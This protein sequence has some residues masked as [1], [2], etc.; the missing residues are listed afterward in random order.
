MILPVSS[1]SILTAAGTFG[2]PGIVMIAPVR[3]TMKPAPAEILRL[4]TVT[5][6]SVGAPSF[7]WSSVKLYCVF[8]TQIGQLPNPRPSNSFACFLASAVRTTRLPP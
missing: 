1:T 8:A 5:S 7:V 6:K 2:R 4:R 3:A